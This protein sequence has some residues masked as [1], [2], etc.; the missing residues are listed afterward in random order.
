MTH[1]NIVFVV[2]VVRQL[3]SAPTVKH[4]P[5]LKQILFYLKGATRLVIL[6]NNHEH[7]CVECFVD[8]D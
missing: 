1:S 7:T 4:W 8:V 5:A 3:M 6:Y 2:C